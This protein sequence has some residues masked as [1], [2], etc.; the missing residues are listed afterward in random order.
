MICIDRGIW[1]HNALSIELNEWE[2]RVY[3]LGISVIHIMYI[4]LNRV[5]VHDSIYH[6]YYYCNTRY[7]LCLY[8]IISSCYVKRKKSPL[9]YGKVP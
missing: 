9:V 1:Y 6:N 7:V 4:I 2:W 5:K 8:I 3:I